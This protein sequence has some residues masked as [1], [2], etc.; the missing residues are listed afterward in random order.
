MGYSKG[1]V[2]ECIRA[3]RARRR[4]SRETLADESG[5]P[6]S[7]IAKYENGE[8]NMSLENAWAFADAFGMDM[9]E[10][11]ERDRKAS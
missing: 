9:D 10:L 2:A 3:N 1:H 7:T 11:F 4:M 8:C 5:I 6:V